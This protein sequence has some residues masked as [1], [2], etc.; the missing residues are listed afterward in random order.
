MSAP[1]AT[2]ASDLAEIGRLVWLTTDQAALLA[3]LKRG[4]I[5]WM[6]KRAHWVLPDITERRNRGRFHRRTGGRRIVHRPSLEQHLKDRR[7]GWGEEVRE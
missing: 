3:G 6:M 4:T 7:H 5:H 2:L 1:C